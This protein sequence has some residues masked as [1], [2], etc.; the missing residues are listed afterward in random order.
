V[1]TLASHYRH[2]AAE[3]RSVVA[4]ELLLEPVE[5][6][7][8]VD[9]LSAT[10]ATDARYY[11][12]DYY[13]DNCATRLRDLLDRAVHGRLSAASRAPS[14]LTYREETLRLT[15]D[16]PVLML[17]LDVAMG[18]NIDQPLTAWQA[19]FLPVHLAEAVRRTR[20][21]TP[22]GEA[23]FVV[24]EHVLLPSPPRPVRAAPPRFWPP[25][26]LAGLLGGMVFA[27]LGALAARNRP[28]R[29]LFAALLGALG[30]AV[31]ALGLLMTGLA[32]FTD[33]VVTYR[34]EN[35]LLC[36]PWS[37]ALGV[38]AI[39]VARGKGVS[40]ARARR[41]VGLSLATSAA[42]LCLK[43]LPWFD[44]KN[45]EFIGLFLPVWSGTMAGLV[46]ASGWRL[47]ARARNAT[48]AASTDSRL[49]A[50]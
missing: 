23:P 13:R 32:A 41:L 9:F 40:F 21:Q 38:I 47:A 2:Y 22:G 4:Q 7:K 6:R 36:T 49:P 46:F 44:Q 3:R 42:A 19:A 48:L 12:Y 31:G 27:G 14:P 15:A 1:T 35:L 10:A 30:L 18:S 28:V 37:V 39:G 11:K 8:L 5:R 33:H 34:N 43:L 16:D 20:V 24:R 45:V 29:V 26:L 50:R 17:G 25:M